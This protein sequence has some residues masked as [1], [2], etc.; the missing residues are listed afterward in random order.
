MSK[1]TGLTLWVWRGKDLRARV[2]RWWWNGA[3][4]RVPGSWGS[5]CADLGQ[6]KGGEGAGAL[7]GSP[8]VLGHLAG[9]GDLEGQKGAVGRRM[10][11][12]LRTKDGDPAGRWEE[13]EH[14]SLLGAG[15]GG[16]L[17]VSSHAA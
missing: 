6:R 4:A 12:F 3:Q 5:K 11:G 9:C 14:E 15:R 10:Q 8:H 2:S 1:N 7:F 16:W 13:G 17:K